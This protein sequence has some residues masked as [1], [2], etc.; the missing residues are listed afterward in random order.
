MRLREGSTKRGCK[1]TFSIA[2]SA[3]DRVNGRD[4]VFRGMLFFL[5]TT[6]SH[7]AVPDAFPD[8]PGALSAAEIQAASD[9]MK[10][11][12]GTEPALPLVASGKRNPGHVMP[13]Y[14]L[15]ASPLVNFSDRVKT[16]RQILC[17]VFAFGGTSGKWQCSK[18]H[19]ELRVSANGIEHV[20]TYQ[21]TQG[22]GDRQSAVDLADFMY[23]RCFVAQYAAIGGRPFTPSPDSDFVSAVLDD[24]KGFDVRTGPLLNGDSYGLEKTDKRADNCRFRIQHARM[25]K[26]GVVLPESYA[27][28]LE[29]QNKKAVEAFAKAQEA[30]AKEAAAKKAA[31]NDA[32]QA[33]ERAIK[34]AAKQKQQQ[35]LSI[36]AAA[37]FGLAVVAAA[38]FG[39]SNGWQWI[40]DGFILFKKSPLVWIALCAVLTIML[41]PLLILIVA[42]A[43]LLPVFAAGLMLGAKALQN[44]ET[45][46]IAHLFAGFQ[47]KKAVLL[48]VGWLNV[49]LLV[50][51]AFAC[52]VVGVLSFVILIPVMMA[53]GGSAAS[54]AFALVNLAFLIAIIAA[55]ALVIAL[56][57]ANWFAPA[58]V[59]FHDMP[60]DAAMRASLRACMQNFR[61]FLVYGTILCILLVIAV[62]PL[63]LGL[64]VLMPI[65]FTSMFA[66]YQDVFVSRDGGSKR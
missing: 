48:R 43:V 17:N 25:S 4:A 26:T 42:P 45:L 30:A 8:Q 40:R 5:T 34:E 18:P 46:R 28:E 64:I 55:L 32:K 13:Y 37:L 57:M 50:R 51:I 3:E 58:L 59:V 7:A 41:I 9:A 53:G 65:I 20:F 1:A 44:G 23:S 31:A 61:S 63:G 24:G 66:S 54:A 29:E 35:M 21:A 47:E 39:G 56:F 27:R 38:L 10:P 14:A 33:A 62:I 36:L 15:F 49:G 19:D 16:R 22:S 11:L 12:L 6:L 2:T 52:V 60:A